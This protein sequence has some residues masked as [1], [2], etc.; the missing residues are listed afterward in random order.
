MA[1]IAGPLCPG[2]YELLR[3]EFGDITIAN[4]GEEIVIGSQRWNRTDGRTEW[5]IV[6]PGEY[7]RVNCAGGKLWWLPRT[8]MYLSE[9]WS[10]HRH[11]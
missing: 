3:R 6:Q 2:L 5:D 8:A 1:Q 7:Y 9:I 4:E 10:V 11:C